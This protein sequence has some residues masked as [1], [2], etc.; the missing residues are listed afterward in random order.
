[1]SDALPPLLT[2]AQVAELLHCSKVSLWRR[3]KA[4]PSWLPPA[5]A[6][7]QLGRHLVFRRADVERALGIQSEPGSQVPP[8]E[9][10]PSLLL[11]PQELEASRLRLKEA[12]K[13]GAK[14][15][16]LERALEKAAHPYD[17]AA[18]TERRALD[19]REHVL[20]TVLEARRQREE[21]R[22]ARRAKSKA[23]RDKTAQTPGAQ[24]DPTSPTK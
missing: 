13:Q 5:S 2:A 6:M 1:M 18:I 8:P 14:E 15:A 9:W 3:R 21:G 7:L 19:G 22:K 4:D 17:L 20:V 11:T 23:R 16:R 12:L 10:A 24:V